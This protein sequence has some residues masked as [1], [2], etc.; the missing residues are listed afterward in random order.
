MFEA[1]LI[2][3]ICVML[4]GGV[5]EHRVDY[6][7]HDSAHYVRVDCLTDTHA[8]EVGL[9]NRRSSYD[10]VHQAVFYGHLTDREP[11]VI[12]VDTDGREDNA[13]YQVERV[14]RMVGVDFRVYDL[15]YLIRMQMTAWLRER[16]AQPLLSN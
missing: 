15:D 13:E 16:R 11:F 2:P 10:S 3:I 1:D 12:L 7:L 4:L 14:A 8:I 9:D 5:P 6:D